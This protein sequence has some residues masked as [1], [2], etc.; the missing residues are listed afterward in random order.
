[1]ALPPSRRGGR[2][3]FRMLRQDRG[4]PVYQDISAERGLDGKRIRDRCH[5]RDAD[6]S[7]T[8]RNR[9]LVPDHAINRST[10]ATAE[11]LVGSEVRKPWDLRPRHAEV[12]LW[13]EVDALADDD[14]DL[15]AVLGDVAGDVGVAT[16]AGALS[17]RGPAVPAAW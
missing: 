5:H 10:V 16:T 1:M 12:R 11:P 7:R 17:Q 13:L 6:G 4:E 14:V 3:R 2:D 15:Q 9:H 8:L